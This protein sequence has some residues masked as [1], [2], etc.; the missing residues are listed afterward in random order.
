[1]GSNSDLV[2]YDAMV[3]AITECHRVDEVKDIRDKA[4]ALEAYARQAKNLDA[5]RK[6][7]DIRL[8]AER[9]AGELLKEMGTNGQRALEGRPAKQSHAATI[10]DLGISKTQS[11]RW[12]QLAE[13]PSKQFE[14]ALRAPDKRPSTSGII[15]DAKPTPKKMDPAALKL[16]GV[17]RDFEKDKICDRDPAK[18]MAAMT[19]TMQAD[20][21]RI[22]PLVM[23]WLSNLL[24]N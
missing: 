16:W 20:M 4:L 12:Q 23:D 22:V 21:H 8:R 9:R 18:M 6:A 24:E 5:E 1:M 17:M 14:A 7:C 15:R 3:H 13:V 19:E 11:S 10:S 2:R